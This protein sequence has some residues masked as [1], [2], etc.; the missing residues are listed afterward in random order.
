MYRNAR[1]WNA[2]NKGY[3]K[4]LSVRLKNRMSP[5]FPNIPCS[6]IQLPQQVQTI[7]ETHLEEQAQILREAQGLKKFYVSSYRNECLYSV[8]TD[9]RNF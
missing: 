1:F 4:Y 3:A 5:L 9:Y 2:C 8:G 6:Y 7:L